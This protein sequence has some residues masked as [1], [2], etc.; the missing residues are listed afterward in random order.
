MIWF[1]ADG[2]DAA[3]KTSPPEGMLAND[4]IREL[5]KATAAKGKRPRSMGHPF[6]HQR[7]MNLVRAP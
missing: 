3:A 1:C 2:M 5:T 7:T 4:N 6:V